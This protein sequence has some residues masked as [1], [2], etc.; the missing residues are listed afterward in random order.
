VQ[1][2]NQILVLEGGRVVEHGTH[3]TLLAG[4]NGIYRRL[5]EL[6]FADRPLLTASTRA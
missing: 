3:A 6:Q 2:A 4:G 5:H 1:H